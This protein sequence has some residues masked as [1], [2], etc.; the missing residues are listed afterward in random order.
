MA[1][2]KKKTSKGAGSAQKDQDEIRIKSGFLQLLNTNSS[3]SINA[4]GALS[5]SS[6]GMLANDL[7]IANLS[8]MFRL[9]KINSIT[10]ELVP[11]Q[12]YSASA[13]QVPAAV[14][15]YIPFGGATPTAIGD[16]ET[17][18]IS[19]PAVPFGVASQ[20]APLT[21]ECGTRLTLKNSDM[22]VLQG[23][24][25]GWLATQNDGTHTSWGNLFYAF[26]STTASLVV[27]YL[28]RTVFDISFKDLMD[29]TLISSLMVQ[30]SSG[31]PATWQIAKGTPL[32]HANNLLRSVPKMLTQPDNGPVGN[33]SNQAANLCPR[34]FA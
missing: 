11:S 15:G 20:T 13:A 27:P 7:S 10:V 29:P 30:H 23:P 22:P 4:I 34:R 16:F 33:R 14:I 9:V 5:T 28:M 24:G 2:G 1:G 12:G 3:A 6:S 32:H 8:D 17:R 19:E 21:K 18:H 26:A 25:G 31:F